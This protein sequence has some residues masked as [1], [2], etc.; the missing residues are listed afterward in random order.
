[1]LLA[2]ERF[3]KGLAC[4]P[5]RGAWVL[6]NQLSGGE[7]KLFASEPFFARLPNVLQLVGA[8]NGILLCY[9]KGDTGPAG[10]TLIGFMPLKGLFSTSS[11]S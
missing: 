1:M 9:R 2:S 6:G 5:G 8:Q 3:G 10:A 4:I 11:V 7:R